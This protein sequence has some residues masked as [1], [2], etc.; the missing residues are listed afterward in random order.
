MIGRKPDIEKILIFEMHCEM[1][2]AG[3]G[4]RKTAKAHMLCLH[5]ARNA[6]LRYD[7]KMEVWNEDTVDR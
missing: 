5:K 2:A 4:Q 6:N 3:S 1:R 7:T